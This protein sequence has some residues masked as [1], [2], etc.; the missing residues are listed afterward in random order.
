VQAAPYDTLAF[1]AAPNWFDIR[2]AREVLEDCLKKR[3]DLLTLRNDIE[4]VLLHPEYFKSPPPAAAL[5]GWS[6]SITGVLN[7]L[8]RHISSVVDNLSADAE[9]FALTLPN[10]LVLPERLLH[11][12]QQV[13]IY[14]HADYQME[15]WQ[16]IPGRRQVLSPGWYDD[17]KHQILVGNDQISSLKVPDGLAVRA[18]EHAWFQGEFIDFTTDIPAV[19]ME[20]NDR[21]SSLV[22]FSV[23]DSPPKVDY[24]VALDFAWGPR[25]LLLKA[26]RYPDLA[27]TSLGVG[28]LS[29]L[30]IPRGFI[31]RLWDGTDFT[32]NSIEFYQDTLAL[33]P[34]WDNR[35]ASIEVIAAS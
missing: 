2:R 31:V 16:G 8:D 7:A 5:N 15:P 29:T 26:G 17:A 10:D 14:S 11:S 23:A 12:S 33:P 13:E 35:A 34:E 25:L 4:L 30:L 3:L 19:P 21:I 22:V 27:A 24:I 32:G 18:Y 6:Q 20:W 1:R 9:F 28:T